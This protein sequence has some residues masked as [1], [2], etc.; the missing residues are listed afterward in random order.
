MNPHFPYMNQCILVKHSHKFYIDWEN[1]IK[2][3]SKIKSKKLAE[4][5]LSP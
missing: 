4:N 3:K 2:I 1:K 5:N